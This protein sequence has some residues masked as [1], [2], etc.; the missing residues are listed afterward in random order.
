MNLKDRITR[1]EDHARPV[2]WPDM[3]IRL[4]STDCRLNP[5]DPLPDKHIGTIH[6]GQPGQPGETVWHETTNNE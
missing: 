3:K 4:V 1:L 6:S 2:E 5:V